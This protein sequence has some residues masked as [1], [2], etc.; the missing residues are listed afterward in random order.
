[1]SLPKQSTQCALSREKK[2]VGLSLS[3]GSTQMAEGANT[4]EGWAEVGRGR[5]S[6]NLKSITSWPTRAPNARSIGF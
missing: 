3:T 6:R 5:L 4:L 2:K 1:M